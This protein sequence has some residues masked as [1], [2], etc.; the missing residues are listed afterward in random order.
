MNKHNRS[1]LRLGRNLT[2]F[3]DLLAPYKKKLLLAFSAIIITNMLGLVFPWS[4]KI[5]IDDIII[6]KKLFLLN[7]LSV[8]IFAAFIA[9]FYF[10]YVREYVSSFIGEKVVCDLRNKLYWHVNRL[11][12]T[13]IEKTS[14]GRLI[15]HIIGDVDRIRDFLFGGALDFIYA[16]FNILFILGI[17]CYLDW[18][19]TCVSIISLPLFAF[20]FI[21]FAPQLKNKYSEVREQ[22]AELTSRLHEVFQGIRVITGFA[23]NEYEIARFNA[24]QKEIVRESLGSHKLSIA[25]WTGSECISSIG[26]LTLIWFGSRAVISNRITVGALM[27]FYSYLGM[28]FY[29]M[30]RLVIINNYYQEA[31]ASMERIRK[32][33]TCSPAII[34]VPHPV[35][36]KILKGNIKFENVCFS[37]DNKKE[38]L[39]D[40]D[41]DIKESEIVALV[42]KSGAGKT[43]IIN[44]LLRFY[45][46]VK[47]IIQIDG[48][49]LKT[50]NLNAYRSRIAMVLQDDYLFSGTIRE[51][52]L[53]GN[54]T[55]SDQD[56]TDAA[57]QAGAHQFIA[58]CSNRYDTIIGER[59]INLSYGQR[60]RISI[61][62]ALLRNP[63]LLILDE[64]T[65][66]V[67]SE[68]ERTIVEKA[69]KNLMH[70]RTTVIIAHRLSA[71]MHA[72][73]IMC[74]DGG[75]IIEKG[76]HAELLRNKN[77]Y[78]RMWLGQ[79]ENNKQRLSAHTA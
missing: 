49:N 79:T 48:N 41:L 32:I 22:Y 25:L 6:N 36:I 68:T 11:S 44:L 24:K 38:V 73:S 15:S 9:K 2:E 16:L 46:P 54:M 43:T 31:A 50:L 8:G 69:Y 45:D 12:V 37:Y 13:Y 1:Y 78:W 71:I 29:P 58:E 14:T 21:K 55:A 75:K 17:L 34:E 60:Q 51:N 18:R 26:L 67:D 53:Y 23:K 56:I 4:I 52:I 61:A 35:R 42:G 64:A 19:L 57:V 40:I 66:N 77:A 76:T 59:G 10:G 47:G 33:L 7:I 74:I 28:L 30:V 5:I 3:L 70:G 72:D 65:S 27:A 39:T 63:S 62:R 20:V